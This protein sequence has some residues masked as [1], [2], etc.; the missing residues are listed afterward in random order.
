MLFKTND[1][2]TFKKFINVSFTFDVNNNFPGLMEAEDDYLKP[3]LGDDLYEQL[4]TSA[5]AESPDEGLADLLSLCRKVIGPLSVLLGISTRHIKIGDSGLK[6]TVADGVENVFGW[7]Y[8]EVKEELKDK[9]AKALDKLW[10]H[11]YEHGDDYDWEDTTEINT[12]FKTGSEFNQ[13]YSL[14]QPHRVF[15]LLKP[16]IKKVEEL[17]IWDAIG[18]AFLEEMKELTESEGNPDRLHALDLLKSA[19][20]HFTI[21]KAVSELTVKKTDNGLTVMLN[22]VGDQPFKGDRTAPDNLL[23]LVRDEALKD[24]Q[25]YLKKLRLFLREKASAELFRTYFESD[26]FDTKPTKKTDYNA[27]RTGIV[28]L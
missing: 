28:R 18:K 23:T 20:A 22:D 15:P 25:K 1:I 9:V 17:F 16:I 6:K 5:N 26:Y 7:E 13:H 12:I 2:T 4:N 8:R 14:H 19:I 21:H 3:I 11:L 27:N 10:Q 24:G